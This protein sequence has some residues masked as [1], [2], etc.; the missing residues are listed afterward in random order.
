MPTNRCV[1]KSAKTLTDLDVT[2]PAIAKPAF[3]LGT[4]S[5]SRALALFL[6]LVWRSREALIVVLAM[7]VVTEAFDLVNTAANAWIIK[8]RSDFLRTC[9]HR[10]TVQKKV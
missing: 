5:L 1:L 9:S 10:F 8:R 3:A 4:R 6:A 7:R 2:Q